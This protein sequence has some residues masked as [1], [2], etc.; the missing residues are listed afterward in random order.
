M[1]YNS[2]NQICIKKIT[3]QQTVPSLL[4][5]QNQTLPQLVL[6]FSNSLGACSLGNV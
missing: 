5:G 3:V 2:I 1:S 4:L 6:D